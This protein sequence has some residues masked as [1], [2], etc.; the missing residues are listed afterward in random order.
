MPLSGSVAHGLLSLLF[1][2]TQDQ[3]HSDG[4][5]LAG[6]GPLTSVMNQE[7]VPQTVLQVNLMEAFYQL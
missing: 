7:I 3:Q 4:T 2:T 1:C 6:L 5:T